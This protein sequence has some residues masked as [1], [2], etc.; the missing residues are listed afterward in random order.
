MTEFR[1]TATRPI[2]S[3]V[4]TAVDGIPSS[5]EGYAATFNTETVIAGLFRET[6]APGAFA[7]SLKTVDGLVRFN[8][9]DDR[10]LGRTSTGTA[11]IR[12][13]T[14]GLPYSVQINASDPLAVSAGAQIA[15][16]DV[17]GSSFAFTVRPP[18]TTGPA[19]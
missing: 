11:T 16:G 8:H 2:V 3:K 17:V 7:D 10:L 18:T 13:D 1:F 9:S 15:R 5:L 14:H 12:E 19:L 4:T 6:I